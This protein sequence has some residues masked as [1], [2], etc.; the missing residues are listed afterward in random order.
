MVKFLLKS[1]EQAI[2]V[3]LNDHSKGLLTLK[4]KYMAFQVLF[5]TDK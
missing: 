5:F 4:C 3:L 1:L 2:K